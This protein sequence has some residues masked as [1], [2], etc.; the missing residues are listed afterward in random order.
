ME[1][2]VLL[3]QTLQLL[4]SPLSLLKIL[5]LPLPPQ[6]SLYLVNLLL[7]FI[8]TDLGIPLLLSHFLLLLCGLQPRLALHVGVLDRRSE[9]YVSLHTD[10]K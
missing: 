7:K 9:R 5:L 3:R 10:T 2:R 6:V 4:K 8:L 1:R